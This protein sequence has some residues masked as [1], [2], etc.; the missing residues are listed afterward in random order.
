MPLMPAI[1]P[2]FL[3][4]SRVVDVMPL[5]PEPVAVEANMANKMGENCM[6][7]PVKIVNK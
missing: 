6:A 2:E 3:E 7:L 4:S 1:Q 5:M